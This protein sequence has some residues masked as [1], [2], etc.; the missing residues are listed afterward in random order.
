MEGD[1]D[2]D[3]DERIRDIHPTA[4]CVIQKEHPTPSLQDNKD[5][6]MSDGREDQ[7]DVEMG[8]TDGRKS[9]FH[10]FDRW[11]TGELEDGLFRRV[12]DI[13]Q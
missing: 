7:E 13:M 11:W 3:D 6:N 4:R 2:N 8:S 5:I 1:D 12:L 9:F 10:P